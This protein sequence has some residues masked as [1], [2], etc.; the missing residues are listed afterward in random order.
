MGSFTAVLMSDLSRSSPGF[1]F[2]LTSVAV[3]LEKDVRF[4]FSLA[5]EEA[6]GIIPGRFP[7][8]ETIRI[9]RNGFVYM[10]VV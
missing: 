8:K 4:Y 6:R 3:S 2:F 7:V 9:P 1:L 10:S 5:Q